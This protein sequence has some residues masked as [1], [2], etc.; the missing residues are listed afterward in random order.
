MRDRTDPLYMEELLGHDDG[1]LSYRFMAD[2]QTQSMVDSGEM[3]ELIPDGNVTW[4]VEDDAEYDDDIAIT[5]DALAILLS[6]ARR[7]D[8]LCRRCVDNCEELHG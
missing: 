8:A 6:K 7:L 2:D 3:A 5:P 4:S 1:S